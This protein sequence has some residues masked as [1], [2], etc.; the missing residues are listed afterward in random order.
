MDVAQSLTELSKVKVIQPYHASQSSRLLVI[1]RGENGEIEIV[2]GEY[3]IQ[4][5]DNSNS[6]LFDFFFN[7]YML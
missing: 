7:S 4:S 2:Q 1:S 5:P 3:L 6:H